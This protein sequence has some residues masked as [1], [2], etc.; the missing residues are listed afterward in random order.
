ME[1]LPHQ[2]LGARCQPKGSYKRG[3]EN[4]L[5]AP[6][7]DKEA[8]A[9]IHLSNWRCPPHIFPG[10]LPRASASSTPTT[11]T[12]SFITTVTTKNKE[13]TK[14]TFNNEHRSL[15]EL[16][17]HTQHRALSRMRHRDQRPA[18]GRTSAWECQAVNEMT[19]DSSRHR[20]Q[21]TVIREHTGG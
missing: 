18:Q 8:T 10:R 1:V 14:N 19:L 7:S 17:T 3:R 12:I 21:G 4:R 2:P 20:N 16:S 15:P 5:G 9:L 13:N 6:S 11:Y